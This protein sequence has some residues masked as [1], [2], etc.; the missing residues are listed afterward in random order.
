[1]NLDY[2]NGY[3][4]S[5]GS[6][7]QALDLLHNIAKTSARTE[8]ERYLRFGLEGKDEDVYNQY[9]GDMLLLVYDNNY[10]YH[11]ANL[12]QEPIQDESIV[13]DENHFIEFRKLL[14]DLAKRKYTGNDAQDRLLA[15]LNKCSIEEQEL[16]VKILKKDLKMGV[17]EKTINKV[18]KNFVPT[19][20]AMLA[21][22]FKKFP[23]EFV[24]QP[25]LDGYRCLAFNHGDYVELRTRNGK[26]IEGFKEIERQISFLPVGYMYDGEIINKNFNGTQKEVF[27]KKENKTGVLNIFDMV[28]IENFYGK[29]EKVK[30]IDRA[31]RLSLCQDVID[32]DELDALKIV[33]S[34]SILR[35]VEGIDD[36]VLEYHMEYTNQGYEGTMVKD[37][38]S[39]YVQKR[40]YGLQKI[41]DFETD[42]LTII[43]YYEGNKG[44]IYEGMLGGFTVDYN[45]TYVD[46]GG[47]YSMEQ[48][49]YFWEHKEEMIDKVIEV[50]FQPEAKGE[51]KMKSLRFPQFKCLREDKS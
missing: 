30:Y 7:R 14:L 41:K 4:E 42:D 43:G 35:N 48:R 9:F 5:K 49:R 50:Q 39:P 20:S 15:I 21:H 17:S 46:V 28:S 23:K 1:M 13:S 51:E 36:V 18:K 32:N 38:T 6:Y 33:E 29:G 37:I 16:F 31:L 25:K 24:L 12:K 34:T 22:P 11:V 8:K 26:A 40:T 27:T 47:G 10:V 3:E 19:F 45:G 2:N 44:T